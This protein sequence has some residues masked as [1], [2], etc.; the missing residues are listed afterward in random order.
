[1]K[2]EILGQDVKYSVILPEDYYATG[3]KYPVVYLLHGLGDDET[4]WLEYGRISQIADKLVNDGEIVPMI[5]VMP[6]GFRNYYV[7]DYAGTFRYE[8]MF[9]NELIPF[10]DSVYH[11]K[12]GGDFRATMGYSMGG[13]GALNIPLKNPE[14]FCA[15]VALSISIRTD[16]QYMYEDAT[17]WNDQWGRLF[18]GVD[19]VGESRITEYYKQN[20][21]IHI[22][23]S[24]DSTSRELPGI[25]IDN[26]DDEQTL[27]FSNEA[28]HIILRDKNIDHEFRVRD[29]GHSFTYWR[30]A[31]PNGLRYISDKFEDNPYQGDR[32]NEIYQDTENNLPYIESTISEVTAR[33]FLP[34]EYKFTNRLYPVIYILGE[35][36]DEE[37][38]WIAALTNEMTETGE[39]PPLIL[40]FIP[41]CGENLKDTVINDLEARYRIRSG[42]RFRGLI[43]F[44]NGGATALKSVLQPTSFTSCVLMDSDPGYEGFAKG[45]DIAGT[46]DLWRTWFYIAYPDKG[47][48]YAE[49]SRIH[50]EFR[51]AD[52]YHE[53]RILE[54]YGGFEWR[55]NIMGEALKFTAKKI[56]R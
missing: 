28:L 35:I 53:Y 39:L 41:A 37:E 23:S 8:D 40:A 51:A 49:N 26:G 2:S 17:E 48:F 15:C 33:L 34:D 38:M 13:F 46:D 36:T 16:E 24:L 42:Y 21:P 30:E 6:Q 22:L 32:Q 18:G 45:L 27:S 29:G 55:K 14:H 19:S 47:D 44:G 1:M 31:L 10:I 12:K 5:F 50:T 4:S 43:G 11:T 54:G 3:K 7:N 56:H 52:Q 20:C 9:M 25:Y